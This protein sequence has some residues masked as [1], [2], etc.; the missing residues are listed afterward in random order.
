MFIADVTGWSRWLGIK[1]APGTWLRDNLG[2]YQGNVTSEGRLSGR[3][4]DVK[5]LNLVL[6]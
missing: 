6:Y 4:D 2:R 5:V 3:D 1:R